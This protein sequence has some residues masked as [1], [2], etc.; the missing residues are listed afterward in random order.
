ML[1]RSRR[2]ERL[3]RIARMKFSSQDREGRHAAGP[4]GVREPMR[5]SPELSTVPVIV[6]RVD[7]GS[8]QQGR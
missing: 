7:S 6:R 3:S 8:N 4:E 5:L 2:S 1:S